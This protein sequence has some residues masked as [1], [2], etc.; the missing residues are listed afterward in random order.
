V[1]LDE[2]Y[3]PAWAR[4]GRM[5]RVMAKFIASEDAAENERNAEAALKRAL[6]LNPDL[7]VAHKVYAQLEVDLG[8]GREAMTR[9]LARARLGS[10]DQELFVG[11]SQACRYCGL[12]KASV[13]AHER[14]RRLDPH[15]PTGVAHTFW[16]MADYERALEIVNES[17]D[18]IEGLILASLGRTDEAIAALKREHPR[19]AGTVMGTFLT[20]VRLALERRGPEL[21]DLVAP[22]RQTGFRDPEG[23]FYIAMFLFVGG[24]VDEGFEWLQLSVDRGFACYP[25]LVRTP[26]LDPYRTDSR[27]RDLFEVVEARHVAARAAYVDAGGERILGPGTS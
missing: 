6:E 8:H 5:Y 16:M 2:R 14:A 12:L 4:L 21:R 23:T 18:A 25:A 13:A 1:E 15:M 24:E 3:A 19:F 11:L 22:L 7:S 17:T 10:A 27:F 9:L 20:G 26:W